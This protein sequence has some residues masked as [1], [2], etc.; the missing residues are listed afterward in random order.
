MMTDTDGH[1]RKLLLELN[2]V[3]LTGS[4]KT[5]YPLFQFRNSDLIVISIS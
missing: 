3:G 5:A 1:R 4:G 2:P